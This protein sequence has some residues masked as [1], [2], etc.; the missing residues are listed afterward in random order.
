MPELSPEDYQKEY[1]AAAA[2]LDAAA[3]GTP[4]VITAPTTE[5][6]KVPEVVPEPVKAAEPTTEPAPVDEIA[7]LK[8]RLA[9]AEQIAH[10]NQVWGTKNAQ[11]LAEIERERQQREREA[12][13]PPILDA[14]PDLADAIRYVAN[15]PA[16]QQEAQQRQTEQQQ[17]WKET[18][19]KAIPGAFDQDLDPELFAA[20]A[21]RRDSP[22]SDWHDPL[23]VI[24]DITAEK[25][26]FAERQA[27]KRFAAESARQAEKSAMSVPGSGG[28]GTR[29]ATNPDLEAINRINNMS[30]AEFAKEVRRVKGF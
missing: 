13:K 14:N 19:E 30:D 16:P 15:D 29:A 8:A 24:R 21:A 25:L 20:L 26:A 18:I 9:K 2:A 7:E 1:D 23:N 4:E 12:S 28:S 6:E 3:S 11:R 22:N 17:R 5:P 10:D 27:G